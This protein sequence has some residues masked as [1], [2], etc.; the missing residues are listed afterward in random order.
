MST[1]THLPVAIA[2]DLAAP[3]PSAQTLLGPPPLNPGDDT[4][5]YDTLVARLVA[6]V[7]PRGVIEEACLREVAEMMWEAARLR[8]LKAK[9]M[10]LSAGKAVREV[11]QS[12]GVEFLDA[13]DLA[14]RWA[15]R[16]LEAVG[17]VDARLNAAGLDMHHVMAKT[18]EMR[19]GEI[20]RIDRMAARAEARRTAALREMIIYRDPVFAGR[21]QAAVAA[22]DEEAEGEM[23]RLPAPAGAADAAA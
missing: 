17:E 6:E 13:H 15:A 9:L 3:L 12:I 11:L 7:G 4:D 21:L 20:E 19:I 16:E 18:L 8:R 2:T 14:P 5:S 10:T 23:A 22:A 1:P